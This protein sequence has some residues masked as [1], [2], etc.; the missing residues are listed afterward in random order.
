MFA[1]QNFVSSQMMCF[2]FSPKKIRNEHVKSK[3][4]KKLRSFVLFELQI[5]ATARTAV[6]TLTCKLFPPVIFNYLLF[7]SLVWCTFSTIIQNILVNVYMLVDRHM[8]YRMLAFV[9]LRGYCFFFS[10]EM[11]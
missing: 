5:P 7:F 4:S 1:M 6:F 9:S 3:L 2:A 8:F 10:T 11:L